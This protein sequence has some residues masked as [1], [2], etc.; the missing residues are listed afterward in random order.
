M[1]LLFSAQNNYIDHSSARINIVIEGNQ[2]I[3]PSKVIFNY[4]TLN[5]FISDVVLNQIHTA[6]YECMC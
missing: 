6:L 4:K 5:V 1:L 3:Y 2:N